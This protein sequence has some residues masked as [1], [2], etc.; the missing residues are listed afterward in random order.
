MFC[1]SKLISEITEITPTDLRQYLLYLGENGHNEGGRHAC[2]RAVKTFLLWWEDE[3]KPEGWKNPIRKV[4]APKAGI[5]PLEP[6]NLNN[7]KDMLTTCERSTF[8][9][10]R[11]RAILLALMDT[12]A[13]A[14]ELVAMRLEDL[15]LTGAILIRQGKGK[16]PRTV[17]LGKKKP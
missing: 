5:E 13:R 8:T 14:G 10:T 9:G 7:I 12:G 3:I 11:D 4:K 17:F 15:D 16:K 6:A 2:Y 1:E